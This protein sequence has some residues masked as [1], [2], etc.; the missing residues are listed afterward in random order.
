MLW[1]MMFWPCHS[2]VKD[3]PSIRSKP[4]S[5]VVVALLMTTMDAIT[6]PIYSHSSQTYKSV[7]QLWRW[8]LSSSS[9][10]SWHYL[11]VPL[12]N[13]AM[14]FVVVLLSLA[15]SKITPQLLRLKLT[16]RSPITKS[17]LHL[18]RM[19]LFGWYCNLL[20]FMF[21]ADSP[22]IIRLIALSVFVFSLLL[23]FPVRKSLKNKS[24]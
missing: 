1:Q 2:I 24:H 3:S 16:K 14:W 15:L 10:N 18:H 12:Q 11:N 22:N 9:E 5:A 6:D 8:Q 23:Q 4:M 20:F 17:T 21:L 7:P 13:F 19:H